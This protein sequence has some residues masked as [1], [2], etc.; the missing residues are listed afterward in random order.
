MNTD[1][2]AGRSI[3]L[4]TD[5]ACL[6]N[7]GP[8]G[9]GCVV[10]HQENGVTFRRHALAGRA[11][12]ITTNQQMELTAAIEGL[13]FTIPMERP[14]TVMS[15]SQYLVNGITDWMPNWI[16]RGWHGSDKKPIKN[17]ALWRTLDQLLRNHAAPVRWTW[18]RGHNGNPLN[19]DADLLATNAAAGLYGHEIGSLSRFHPRFFS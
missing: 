9:W 2:Y 11:T 13:R 14:I 16:K 19:E 1:N 8:G 15:D 10:H 17:Q 6:G 7:P 12:G 4:A 3:L 5:G 18:V